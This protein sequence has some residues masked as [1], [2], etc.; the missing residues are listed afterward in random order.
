MSKTMSA[1]IIVL[2]SGAVLFTIAFIAMMVVDTINP[3]AYTVLGACMWVLQAG[4]TLVAAGTVL[5]CL[6]IAVDGIV[7]A[8]HR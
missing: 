6:F 1:A 8:F 7:S 2:V 3:Y 5:A 4:V